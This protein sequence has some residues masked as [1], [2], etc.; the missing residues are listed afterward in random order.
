MAG[1]CA[2]RYVRCDGGGRM[3]GRLELFAFYT[4]RRCTTA[5][6]SPDLLLQGGVYADWQPCG[7]VDSKEV[8]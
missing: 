6:A 1:R 3:A 7:A 2:A 5:A 8:W 4:C